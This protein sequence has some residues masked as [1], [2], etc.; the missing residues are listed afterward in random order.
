MTRRA[1]RSRVIRSAGQFGQRLASTFDRIRFF[2]TDLLRICEFVCLLRIFPCRQLH[3]LSMNAAVTS[4]SIV[5][6]EKQLVEIGHGVHNWSGRFALRRFY[7]PLSYTKLLWEAL[8]AL[9][10]PGGNQVN[11]LPPASIFFLASAGESQW[12]REPPTGPPK[13]KIL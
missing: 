3:E 4:R 1:F 5:R 9:R 13:M 12:G 2:R 8:L 6:R 7:P 11:G 10:G